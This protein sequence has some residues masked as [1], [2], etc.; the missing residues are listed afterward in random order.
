MK[1]WNLTVGQG[2]TGLHLN[3]QSEPQPGPGEVLLKFKAASLNFR[4][5][6]IASGTYPLPTK[7]GVIPL[8]D[9]CWEVLEIGAGVTRV[10]PGDRVI[11]IFTSGW[12][13][14]ELE[15][16]MWSSAF[17][18]EIDGVA[19]QRRVL[20]ESVL[21]PVPEYLS[22]AEAATLA[23]AATTAWSALFW[24]PLPLRPGQTVLALGTG[25]VSTFAVQLAKAAGARVIVTSSSDEKLNRMSAIGADTMINYS[26]VPNWEES[27]LEATQGNGVDVVVE[28]GGPGTLARSLTSIRHGGRV[29]LVGALSNPEGTINPGLVLMSH[30]HVHGVMVGSR[31]DTSDLLKHMQANMIKPLIHQIYDFAE[32]P[33]AYSNLADG[34]HLGKLVIQG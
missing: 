6:L 33:Q 29:A 27:V 13:E 17:G 19:S 9:A 31:R 20:D 15:P 10:A 4:D 5:T 14:G 32:L 1:V 2:A 3:E 21:L 18:C 25:G 28:V 22:D 16:W 12:L 26:D 30:G 24:R 8:S 7:D 23:C 11:N 34:G